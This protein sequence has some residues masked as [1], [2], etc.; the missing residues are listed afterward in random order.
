MRLLA[1]LAC[2]ILSS[3]TTIYRNGQKVFSTSANVTGLVIT[4]DGDIQAARIDSSSAVRSYGSVVGTAAAGALPIV[5]SAI[6]P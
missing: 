1:C 3:C 5:T 4:K 6:R 2:L